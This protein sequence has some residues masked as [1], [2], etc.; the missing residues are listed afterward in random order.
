MT[1]RWPQQR[2]DRERDFGRPSHRRK[3]RDEDERPRSFRKKRLD[4]DQPEGGFGLAGWIF[5]GIVTG[6]LLERNRSHGL[7][8]PTTTYGTKDF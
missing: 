5:A 4:G 7:D 8:M 2:D 6:V 3:G 1:N